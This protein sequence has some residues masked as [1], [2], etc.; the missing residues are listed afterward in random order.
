M[1]LGVRC[2]RRIKPD[3]LPAGRFKDDYCESPNKKT[4]IDNKKGKIV[5]LS[6]EL[7]PIR[8]K[9]VC[10]GEELEDRK[11]VKTMVDVSKGLGVESIGDENWGFGFDGIG[12]GECYEGCAGKDFIRT[13]VFV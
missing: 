4:K 9:D 8:M 7:G 10:V 1:W 2:V 12:S 5:E 11:F 6:R 3:E 13:C